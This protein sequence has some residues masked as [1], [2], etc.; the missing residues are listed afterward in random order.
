MDK[1]GKMVGRRREVTAVKAIVMHEFGSADVLAVRDVPTPDPGPGEVRVA[2][3]AVAVARTKDVATRSGVH[4]FSKA[5]SLPHILGTEHAG[6]IDAVGQGVRASL[7][8]QR[9]A[10]SAVVACGRC[11]ACGRGHEEACASFG[12]VGIHRP[13]AYAQFSVVPA[14]NLFPVPGDL[15]DAD[16]AALAANGPVAH[17]QLDA[18]GVGPGS[19]V[20]VP[21]AAG[22]LGSTVAQLAVFRGARVIAVER[23]GGKSGALDGL[24]ALAV[25]DGESPTLA[26][27]IREL[28]DG[29]GADCVVDNLGIAALWQA[30]Y[31]AVAD[32]G[33]IVVSGAIGREPVPLELGPLYLRSQSIIGIRT[34]NRRHMAALWEDVGRGFRLRSSLVRPMPLAAAASAH[35]AV[36][37]GEN[38]GQIVLI[39]DPA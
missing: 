35:R 25:L 6:A 31:P 7:V 11:R 19:T 36:E 27:D 1:V 23:A 32:L 29:A 15:D 21:G 39:P 20:V 13:G 10:V 12:L 37:N 4:P 22:A 30:Y 38:R 9:V 28:T 18:G 2:V 33:R 34:G 5:V 8:G 14:E 3:R 17:S 16:A 24:G 26:Q